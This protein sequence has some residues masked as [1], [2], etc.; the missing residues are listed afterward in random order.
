VHHLLVQLADAR[1]VVAE[2]HAV[3]TAVRDRAGVH[4]REHARAAAAVQHVV[5]AVPREARP[6]VGEVVRRV[7][8]GQHVEH[9]AQR[10]VRQ[11]AK[12]ADRRT[13]RAR[14]GTRQSCTGGHGDDVLRQHVQRVARHA[15]R[16]DRALAHALRDDR[17][18]EQVA[19]VLREDAADADLAHAVARAADALQPARHRARRLDEDDEVDRAHVDAELERARG[20]DGRQRAR[21]Q[22]LLDLAPLLVRDAAV[23]RA[24]QLL[25][26]LLVQPL[27]Q[28]LAQAAAVHEHDGRAVRA[29]QLDD[30]RIDGR[31]DAVLRVASSW[32]ASMSEPDGGCPRAAP[33][34]AVLRL[35]DGPRHVLHGHDDLQVERAAAGACRRW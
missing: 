15:Q 22:R 10:V 1:A 20:D 34:T 30:A 9:A 24:H 27:R 33:R 18:L 31:P 25:A 3:Q 12:L 32:S 29:D 14:S 17:R 4:G 2:E 35:D 6:Q 26:G 28:P 8:P 7:E 13:T 5:L 23:M 16:L 19:A 21:L 11:R